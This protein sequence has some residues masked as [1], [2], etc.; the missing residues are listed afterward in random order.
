MRPPAR[1]TAQLTVT[2][3]QGATN[4]T[5]VPISVTPNSVAAPS[6][7]TATVSG[8]NVTLRWNDNSANESG[9]YVERAP[10]GGAFARIA[11]VGAN[12]VTYIETVSKGQYA[13]RVQAFNSA[14][15]QV[16]TDSNQAQAKVH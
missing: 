14:T 9:F 1:Y 4:S 2:D 13:Y 3:N 7:L 8:K 11:T 12:V 10:Q 6:N 15:G 16:S 5:S